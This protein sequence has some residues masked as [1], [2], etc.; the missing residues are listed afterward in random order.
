MKIHSQTND[1]MKH[2]GDVLKDQ[3]VAMLTLAEPSGRLSSRPMTALEL[4]AS[5]AFWMFTSKKTLAHLFEGGAS[6][7]V[8]FAFADISNS[9]YVSIEGNAR[10]VDDQARKNELWTSMARPYFPGGVD[11]PELIV[12]TIRT[13][14]AEI[15]D[16]P[17]SSIVRT[18]AMAASIAVARPVGL[19]G[20]EV[21]D[22]A[23]AGGSASHGG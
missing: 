1:E 15:W 10:L 13:E 3:R 11:D 18:I 22:Q 17:D 5:G 9:T 16:S 14:R 23:A 21:I 20:H 6:R 19:G 4:D 7:Q 2:L 8:N 12:L